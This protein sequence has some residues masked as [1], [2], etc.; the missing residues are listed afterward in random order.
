[1]NLG[2]SISGRVV[3]QLS[4]S[5]IRD[6]YVTI[7]SCVPFYHKTNDLD[8]DENLGPLGVVSPSDFRFDYFAFISTIVLLAWSL[9]S[10]VLT[11]GCS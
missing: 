9:A 8:D 1:L 11:A 6:L 3:S 4:V 7:I 2:A 5:R 10:S